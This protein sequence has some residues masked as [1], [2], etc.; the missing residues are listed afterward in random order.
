MLAWLKPSLVTQESCNVTSADISPQANAQELL[1]IFPNPFSGSVA[2][3]LPQ[4]IAGP[5]KFSLFD[6]KGTTIL[7]LDLRDKQ[8]QLDV[9]RLPPGIY[10]YMAISQEYGSTQ[11][12]LVK[13]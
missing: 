11:G 6:S 8:T 2:I 7:T 9:N 4:A 5:I 13:I 1:S 12:K 3:E 10:Y